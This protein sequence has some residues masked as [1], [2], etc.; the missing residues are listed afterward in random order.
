MRLMSR[1]VA[2]VASLGVVTV[3]VGCATNA[4]QNARA[5]NTVAQASVIVG[6]PLAIGVGVSR[7]HDAR[8]RDADGRLVPVRDQ[9]GRSFV[10]EGLVIGGVTAAIAAVCWGYMFYADATEAEASSSESPSAPSEAAPP[11]GDA[12]PAPASSP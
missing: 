3:L 9:E 7:T 1:I 10:V 2:R 12:P 6:V 4:S 11:V 8:L 5:A